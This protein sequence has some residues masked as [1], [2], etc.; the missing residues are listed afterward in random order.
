MW[1]AH[2]WL[3]ARL[4]APNWCG[5]RPARAALLTHT[6]VVHLDDTRLVWARPPHIRRSDPHQ[7]ATHE[8]LAAGVM[9]AAATATVGLIVPHQREHAARASPIAILVLIEDSRVRKP[10]LMANE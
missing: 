5:G 9:P 2:I 1:R 10:Y 7:A 8:Q 4:P 3:L 6:V